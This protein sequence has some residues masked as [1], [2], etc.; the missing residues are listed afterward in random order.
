MIRQP[1]YVYKEPLV[2]DEVLYDLVNSLCLCEA[3]KLETKFFYDLVNVL[4]L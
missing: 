3:F 2:K 1:Y 4:R